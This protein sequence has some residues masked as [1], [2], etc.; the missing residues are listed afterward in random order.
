VYR[1]LPLDDVIPGAQLAAEAAEA[2]GAQGA[3]WPMQDRLARE[4]GPVTLSTIYRAARGTHLDLDRFFADLSAH[5][6]DARVARDV[7]S[8]D[9]SGVTGTPAFFINGERYTGPYDPN[10]LTTQV[11]QALEAHE[12]APN[13]DAANGLDPMSS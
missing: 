4:E 13:I 9:E 7:V 12:P 1:H 10:S 6:H 2:A 3:F 5:K 11:Q 8:A